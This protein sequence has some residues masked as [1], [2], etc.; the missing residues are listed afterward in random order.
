[1][2]YLEYSLSD[3]SAMGPEETRELQSR[4]PG[5][6]VMGHDTSFHQNSEQ[7]NSFT[8][9]IFFLKRQRM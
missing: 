8:F 4:F 9:F 2:F 6:E 7:K 5:D 3:L 1:M